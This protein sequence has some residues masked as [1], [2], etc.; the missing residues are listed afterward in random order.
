[1]VDVACQ[2]HWSY[3]FEQGKGILVRPLFFLIEIDAQNSTFSPVP[4][5]HFTLTEPPGENIDIHPP[6]SHRGESESVGCPRSVSPTCFRNVPGR[7]R[8]RKGKEAGGVLNTF[9]WIVWFEGHDAEGKDPRKLGSGFGGI[10]RCSI[11]GLVFVKYIICGW[12]LKMLRLRL[13]Y[14]EGWCVALWVIL[15]W[16]DLQSVYRSIEVKISDGP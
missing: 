12:K 15:T 2:S 5:G 4:W 8:R 9:P 3:G 7:P 14:L 16:Y 1:M 6:I 13:R 11:Q 10:E